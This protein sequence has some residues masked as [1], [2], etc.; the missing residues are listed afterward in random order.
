MPF[1]ATRELWLV[2]KA[3]DEANRALRSFSGNVRNVGRQVQIAEAMAGKADAQRL[4]RMQRLR[5]ATAAEIQDT[6]N[7]IDRYDGQ[8]NR[9]RVLDAQQ[10]HHR[11][12][13]MAYNQQLQSVAATATSAGL[14]L[15][16]IGVA[17]LFAVKKLVDS[18]VEY[19]R[20]V[21]L[22]LTQVDGFKTS[23]QEL[24]DVGLEVARN[25]AVPFEQIQSSLYDIFSSTSANVGQSKILLEA[26]SKTAVAG[27]VDLQ[28]ASR[29]TIAILNAFNIPF[30]NVNALMD[31]QF[32]LVRKGVGTYEEF[33]KVFGRIVP[34][35][36]RAGQ[37]FETVAAMLA[38][39]TRNGLSAAMAATSG[40]RA[41]DAFSHPRSVKN[42]E[43]LGI[44]M[45]DVKGNLVPL[46]DILDQLRTKIM[47]LPPSERVGALVDIFKGAGGTIQARRFYEQILLRP[48]ELEQFKGFLHDMQNATGQ[49][50]IAYGEM[51]DTA[52]SKSQLLSN[53]WQ[54]VKI[55]AGTALIPSFIKVIDIIGKLFE[56]F[57]KL[58]PQQQKF[59]VM[60]LGT[61]AV[62]TTLLGIFLL[63]IGGIAAVTAAIVSAG[64]AFFIVTGVI[65]GVIAGFAALTAGTYIAWKQ[66]KDFRDIIYDLIDSG[67]RLYYESI[68]PTAKGIQDA[69]LK[70][71]QPALYNL[72]DVISNKVLPVARDIADRFRDKILPA[73]KELG[74]W[75]RDNL[76]TAFWAVAYMINSWLIPAISLAT[77][78][79]HQHQGTVDKVIIAVV[80]FTKMLLKLAEMM[81]GPLTIAFGAIIITIT[82]T[83]TMMWLLAK[84]IETVVNWIKSLVNWIRSW[85][86][87]A[88][89]SVKNVGQT[90]TV[91]QDKLVGIKNTI[92]SAFK[93]MIRS[94][95]TIGQD[96][97]MGLV[98]GALNKAK[99]AVD[100]VKSIA[101]SLL[102]GAKS[103]LGIGSPSKM[104][105]KLGRDSVAGYMLGL[106]GLNTAVPSM[107]GNMAR[108]LSTNAVIGQGSNNGSNIN[109]NINV[110]TQEINPRRHSEELG[111]LLGAR[112]R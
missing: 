20:Q 59:I 49:F 103:V 11:R 81:A 104:F 98:N 45:R 77:K 75:L 24:G 92:I 39:L 95:F 13:L 61:A 65:A 52:A 109:Q 38:Y 46:V 31:V 36:T 88:K 10:E 32:Q 47:K 86:D 94:F 111:F 51:A 84:I 55:A 9:L 62:L 23:V 3:R 78:W 1:S 72:W 15:T 22:T 34:S 7:L 73:A 33:A 53:R 68:L 66:S 35:A 30:E 71:M 8:I 18:A 69:W 67:K 102:R 76:A 80:W 82:T 58:T 29:G 40:A 43:K 54:A 64:A 97:I 96:M 101:G 110:F 74:N 6:K 100:T 83:L 89:T 87:G 70:Y 57:N 42:L 28:D 26:F 17:S 60:L 107:M 56:K 44:K 79:Y 105:M 12:T 5:G 19:Q 106:K 48:G 14:I 37:T 41:L 16:G 2:L 99:T 93:T 90:F 50:G 85:D 21:R 108:T 25:I 4:L 27:Q 91:F 112:P 63:V